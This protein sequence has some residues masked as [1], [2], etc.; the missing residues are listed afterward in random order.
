MKEAADGTT[1]EGGNPIGELVSEVDEERQRRRGKNPPN[2][3]TLERCVLAVRR[4]LDDPATNGNPS[5]GRYRAW[6][7]GRP[8]APSP[9]KFA[10]YGGWTAVSRLARQG[11]PIPEHL[12][13]QTR[14]ERMEAAVLAL[15]DERGRI[16][17]AEVQERLA[18]GPLTAGRILKGLKDRG[19]IVVGS[20]AATGRWVFY[21]RATKT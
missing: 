3:W 1:E 21:V 17:S 15:I 8:D 11:W 9:S 13:A 5:Q 20:K 6:A 7:S 18:V 4:Y 10:S 14:R 12:R 19:E 16:K 2:Y